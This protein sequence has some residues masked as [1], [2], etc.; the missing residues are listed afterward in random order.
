MKLSKHG[1]HDPF[2]LFL[3]RDVQFIEEVEFLIEPKIRSIRFNKL[4]GCDVGCD[5]GWDDGDDGCDDGCEEGLE[6][7]CVEGCNDGCDDGLDEG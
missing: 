1:P 5:D 2:S 7:G 4:D 3:C 6:E